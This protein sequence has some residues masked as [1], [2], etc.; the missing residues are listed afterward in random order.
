MFLGIVAF[1]WLSLERDA[2]A[3]TS[4]G[5]GVV[6]A[7]RGTVDV[8]HAPDVVSREGLAARAAL[9]FRGDVFFRDVID[10]QRES[11]ARLLLKGR[12]VFTVQELSRVELREGLVPDPTRT[13]SILTLLAGGFRALIQRELRPG[14]EFEIHTPNAVAAVR[15][16]DLVAETYAPGQ[17]TPER[18]RQLQDLAPPG[19][20]PPRPDEQVTLFWIRDAQGEIANPT[21]PGRPEVGLSTDLLVAVIGARPPIRIPGVVPDL[22]GAILSRAVAFLRGAVTPTLGPHAVAQVQAGQN[23]ATGEA[24]PARRFQPGEPTPLIELA[25][26]SLTA[27]PGKSASVDGPVTGT[28]VADGSLIGTLIFTPRS[29]PLAGQKLVSQFTSE[30]PLPAFTTGV[31]GFASGTLPI[32][33]GAGSFSLN[34]NFLGGVSGSVSASGQAAI[35]PG[36]GI[37]ANTSGSASA[38]ILP[39]GPSG[40]GTVNPILTPK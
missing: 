5:V 24:R 40:S 38:L 17:L 33:N 31:S 27:A 18:L 2:A 35:I 29:G 9:R 3:Y 14:D 34:L 7:L 1:V 37:K 30:C 13:R 20:L 28:L 12:A 10:T 4:K 39:S 15:G 11:S 22:I 25:L 19:T 16:T 6:T 23:R 32:L 36:N 21:A 8:T 26:N